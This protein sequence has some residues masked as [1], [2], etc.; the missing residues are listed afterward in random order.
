MGRKY[1]GKINNNRVQPSG[2]RRTSSVPIRCH[3]PSFI[4]VKTLTTLSRILGVLD[5][6][7]KCVDSS[8][9]SCSVRSLHA[10]AMASEQSCQSVVCFPRS[11]PSSFRFDHLQQ[12]DLP[13]AVMFMF[14][15]IDASLPSRQAVS[16]RSTISRLQTKAYSSLNP[17]L[18]GYSNRNL[19]SPNSAKI[20]ISD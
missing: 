14:E 10:V 6:C 7:E 1:R 3:H 5:E 15:A 8:A 17:P 16:P 9:C 20:G 2:E 18:G 4:N 11:P 12:P 19:D 13:E